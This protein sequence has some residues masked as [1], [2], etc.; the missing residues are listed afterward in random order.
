MSVVGDHKDLGRIAQLKQV[1]R[2]IAACRACPAMLGPPVHGPAILSPV[3]LVGQAPGPHEGRL[4]RPFAYTAGKTLFRWFEESAG[5]SEAQFRER[6]YMAAVARCFPGKGSGGGDRVPDAGE[7]DRCGKHLERELAV[8]RPELILAVGKLAIAQVLGPELYGSHA[9]LTDVVGK[10]FNVEFR[11]AR[12][13][14]ICL[15]HPSGLSSWHKTEPGKRLLREA[16]ERVR[17]H[18]A[19]RNGI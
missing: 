13:D 10:V 9:R 12:A 5:I 19:W 7:I 16:L 11:G 6:V 3:L 18:R 8:L 4:G 15:P 14:V 17:G 2:E 1:Q